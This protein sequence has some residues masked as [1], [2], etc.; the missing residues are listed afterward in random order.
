MSVREVTHRGVRTVRTGLESLGFGRAAP[1]P[2]DAARGKPWVERLPRELASAPYLAAAERILAGNFRLFAH[3]DFA[4]GF[5]PDWNRDPRA[6]VLAPLRFGKGIDYRDS[7]VVGDIKYLWELNRHLELVTLAQA[8]HL[9]GE[10]RFALGCRTLL[11]SWLEQ[12][13]YPQGVNWTSS[14][15]VALRLTNWSCAWHLLGGEASPLFADQEGRS[16]HQSWLASIFRHCH[17]IAGNLSEHSSANNHLLGELLGLMLGSCTW[18]CWPQTRQWRAYARRR[19]AEQALLQN[20]TDGV[21]REQAFWYQHEVAD[22]MLLAGLTARS[23][24]TDF[25]PAYWQRLEASLGCLASCMDRGGNVPA[26]GDADDAVIVRFSPDMQAAVD[27]YRSLLASGGVLFSRG[28]LRHKAAHFDDKSRW[29]LGDAAAERFGRLVPES[30]ESHLPR[31]F[32]LGGYYVLGSDFGGAHEVRVVADAGPLGYLSLAAHGHADALSFTLSAG[33]APV[34]VDTGTYCYHSEAAWRAYFRGTAAHNTL[35]VDGLDQS[36][37]GGNFLWLR[38]AHTRCLLFAPGPQAQRL[39]AEHDGYLRL[40]DPVRHR[41]EIAYDRERAQFAVEDTLE[42]RAT[43]RAEL[44]WHF[45]EDCTVTLEAA[46][47]RVRHARGVLTLQWPAGMAAQLGRGQVDPPLGWRSHHF[48][49]KVP[50]SSLCISGEVS[51]SWRG[52]TLIGLSWD[53]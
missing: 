18:P 51:G 45:A 21:N 1:P 2:P 52:R 10:L 49:E 53:E 11:Q 47:A 36:V 6:G 24:G 4:L 22:M 48:G 30:T 19:L 8:W 46:Q 27:V 40:A 31:A 44:F 43:H 41:R 38:H 32:P 9:S 15:E 33:G 20:A 5:P 23:N 3:Y 50:C 37:P 42:C 35:R 16:L 17:F 7:R 12:C 34:L 26:F 14:L 39:I 13:P 28:D 25:E 29:L